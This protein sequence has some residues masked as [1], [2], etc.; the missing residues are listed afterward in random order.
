MEAELEFED[1]LIDH[2]TQIGGSK[3]WQYLPEIKTTDQLWQ[4]FKT[5]LERNNQDKL[6]QPLSATEFAQVKN[7]IDDLKTPYLAGKFL[8][9]L[10]GVSQVEIDTD[11]GEHVF[12]TVFDQAFV[13][14]GGTVYQV[15]NQIERPA[16]LANCRSRRFD[17]TLLINGLPI[18]Q[19]EEKTAARNVKEAL[20]QM[21]QYIHENQFSDIYSTVQI[22][23]GMT[24]D[25]TRYM[26]NTTED[27]FN[28]DFAFHWQREDNNQPV[29]AW[30]DFLNRMMS[31]PMAHQ[32][33]T[34]YMI[35]DGTKHHQMLK[36]MRPYQVYATR[37]VIERIRNA[38]FDHD[39]QKL[40]YIWHTTGSGKTISS[41]KTA[42]L[43]SRLP[44]VDKVVFLV[45]RIALTQQTTDNYSAYDPDTNDENKNGIISDTANVN[46]LARKLRQ[47]GGIIVTSIQ[48]LY[49]LVQRPNFKKPDQHIVFIVD[50]AHRS[51]AGNMLQQTKNGFPHG[52]WVGYTG[53]PR[54][55]GVTT[56]EIFG[57]LLHAYTIREAIADRN[58]LGFK[59][60]FNTT[61]SEDVLKEQYLPQFYQQ[62]HPDWTQ[63]QIHFKIDHLSREDMDDT[64]NSGVYDDNED[65]VKLVV[66]DILKKWRNRSVNGRYSAMLT[67]N[68]GG[69][70]STPMAMKYFDEFQRRNAE[71]PEEQRLKVAVTFSQDTTNGRNMLDNNKGLHEAMMAYN[72]LFGTAFGDDNVRGYTDDVVSRLNRTI[73][74]DQADYLNL[75]IVI[76]QLLTGFDA[77]YLNTLYVDRTLQGANLIQAY[78]R[79]NRIQDM[80][81]KPYGRIVNYRW[82]A[83]TEKLMNDALHTY[84]D[85][86]SASIQT[87]LGGTGVVAPDF[88]QTVKN[89]KT[90]LTHLDELT[91]GFTQIPVGKASVQQAFN[92]LQQYNHNMALLKQDD[93]YDYD[94]PDDL[95]NK[96]GL[97]EEEEI[98]LTST[99]ANGIKDRLEPSTTGGNPNSI[100]Y[101][102]FNLEMEHVN[103]VEVDYDYLEELIANFLNQSNSGDQE[104]ADKSYHRINDLADQLE[105]RQYSRQIKRMA[106]DVHNQKFEGDIV[107]QY[108]VKSDD[109]KGIL[110][111]HNRRG[112]RTAI[113]A[114]RTKW[115]LLDA[116]GVRELINMVLDRHV[117]GN[118]D[119]N[120]NNEVTKI[121]SGGQK[122]Y[123][124][125]AQNEDIRE[126]SKIKYRN[127]LR[128]ELTKFADQINQEFKEPL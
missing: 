82:P 95:L 13:G 31:I 89:T 122:Y 127:Q 124:T 58:V 121:I 36:V 94:H 62:Q 35:L 65:H 92:L 70:S 56:Q 113:L 93:Q 37:K 98:R 52:A 99:I 111:E 59:V 16:K 119:L 96:V 6:K 103:E 125:D 90:L 29:M 85:R 26:A 1:R 50:E 14:A 18:I 45:D 44:N 106:D 108:P 10:N 5:I 63:E 91:S 83:Q 9:G 84:A 77:P 81:Q 79:T 19:I 42:W 101:G 22:L 49:R 4:N 24:P 23:V 34:S 76:N 112:R 38:S 25:D 47:H 2:L 64:V 53:T 100:D 28:L 43:A 12:L 46:M 60:D 3:Q 80:Q 67:T 54:F 41:F 128:S 118:D 86:N 20:N 21:H 75:V 66:E 15:V 61:L 8:Y 110:D 126:L 123:Q 39:S 78:S 71:L 109:V 27:K 88:K 114:F 87:D 73:S 68:V 115:G 17:T 117:V 116:V 48:K 74:D 102:E 97:S 69:G 11:A 120:E 40:G 7:Q 30:R 104:A 51:T 32:M 57:D 33:A 55:E 107:H 105:D 72:E